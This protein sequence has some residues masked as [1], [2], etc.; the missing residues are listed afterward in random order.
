MLNPGRLALILLTTVSLYASVTAV[1]D[2]NIVHKGETVT[3]TLNIE[4]KEFSVP[5]AMTLCGNA[6][7]F[8]NHEQKT[9]DAEGTFKKIEQYRFRFK[10]E[11]DCTVEPILVVVDGVEH[12]TPALN[13]TLVQ[14]D[15]Q[16]DK[17]PK[18]VMKSRKK[19]LYVGEVFELEVLFVYPK[20]PK[21]ADTIFVLPEMK[22]LW[23]KKAYDGV[24]SSEGEIHLQKRRYLLTPQQAGDLHIDPAEVKVAY[25]KSELDA[26]GNRKIKRYWESHYSNRLELHI[27]DLPEGVRA[28]GE[29]TLSLTVDTREAK[30]NS[31]V[32]AELTLQGR[33]NFEDITLDQPVI[34]GVDL[35]AEEPLLEKV[36]NSDDE[37]LQQRL[38]FVGR[39]DFTIPPI[40]LKYFDPK[41]GELRR[42][43]TKAVAI[44]IVGDDESPSS[45]EM[46]EE[47]GEHTMALAV[48][49]LL[50]FLSAVLLL[51]VPWKRYLNAGK[52]KKAAVHDH[53]A[54]LRLLLAH[55][56]DEGVQE[57]LEALEKELYSGNGEGVD[58]KK[59]KK[60]LRRYAKKKQH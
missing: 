40:T 57:M 39:A 37:R 36:V 27:K 56:D 54:A 16:T 34:K 17:M 21:V 4:G 42:V 32:V 51:R 33:G 18:V 9:E 20:S 24:E 15:I 41:S 43:E 6:S 53:R 12:Y 14:D 13:I 44:H 26:W 48:I 10:V 22:H 60:L 38:S 2:K 3:L 19:G 5:S 11:S 55:K 28:V 23:V 35:F 46:T 1:V 30:R 50:G 59:L 7:L 49:Y 58:E 31:P 8:A 45:G 47:K 25:D 52:G 29:F